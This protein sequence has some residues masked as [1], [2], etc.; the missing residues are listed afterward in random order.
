MINFSLL[1]LINDKCIL[2][3]A[4]EI[5]DPDIVHMASSGRSSHWK[6]DSI[7]F[8]T[9]AIISF[10]SF[11]KAHVVF[12]QRPWSNERL[13]ITVF[14]GRSGRYPAWAG[15]KTNVEQPESQFWGT[16]FGFQIF[17][18]QSCKLKR[19]SVGLSMREKKNLGTNWLLIILIIYS[20][21]CTRFL[22]FSVSLSFGS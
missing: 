13:L 4:G 18:Y 3:T 8:Q 19:R 20:W 5:P 14:D 7:V 10:I 21:M 9:M 16:I 1:P 11:T 17:E 15:T 2:L 6:H 22:T 12:W